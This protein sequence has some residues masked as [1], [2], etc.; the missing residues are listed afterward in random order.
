MED[1]NERQ[2]NR[3]GLGMEKKEDRQWGNTTDEEAN[4]GYREKRDQYRVKC[5]AISEISWTH[6]R[7][8]ENT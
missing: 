7:R 1:R 8:V 3:D 6:A 4:G 2:K 5:K